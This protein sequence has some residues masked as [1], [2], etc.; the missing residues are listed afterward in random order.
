[1]KRPLEHRRTRI[2][3]QAQG[4]RSTAPEGRRSS[5]S[6]LLT[7]ALLALAAGCAHAAPPPS[8]ARANCEGTEIAVVGATA[9]DFK[10]V[11]VGVLAAR[12]F[13]MDK[14]LPGE[15][16][17]TLE[18]TAQLPESV[19]P[20][21][22][23]CFLQENKRAYVLTYA[24]FQKRRTWFGVPITRELYRSLATHETAHAIAACHFTA[25]DPSIQAKEYVA[26]VTMFATMPAPLRA[27]ALKSLPGIGFSDIERVSSF[28]YLFDPMQFGANAYRHFQGVHNPAA[29]LADV[30]SGKVLAE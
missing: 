19:G 1:M 16:V 30:M 12:R 5:S 26:Y 21:A 8:P 27:K 25:K 14:G 18:V 10:D 7:G 20:S 23:G 15:P 17:L 6:N 9:A 4:R 22:A 3:T 28:V 11:C 13:L 29:F 24:H 2:G